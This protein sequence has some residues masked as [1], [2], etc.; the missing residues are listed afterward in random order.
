M[1]R[2]VF[3]SEQEAIDYANRP[4]FAI[5]VLMQAGLSESH[6]TEVAGRLAGK[7]LLSASDAGW[8]QRLVDVRASFVR[9]A[10]P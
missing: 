6:A 7:A 8:M 9:M 4:G 10:K 3:E 2:Q 5:S 1:S